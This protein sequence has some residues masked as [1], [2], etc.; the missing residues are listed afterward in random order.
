[1]PNKLPL[2]GGDGPRRRGRAQPPRDAHG[3]H[4]KNLCRAIQDSHVGGKC[5]R[6]PGFHI[7]GGTDA[8]YALSEAHSGWFGVSARAVASPRFRAGRCRRMGITMRPQLRVWSHRAPLLAIAVLV[9]CFA[10]TLS[11]CAH[12]LVDDARAGAMGRLP[13]SPASAQRVVAAP[14]GGAPRGAPPWALHLH[15]RGI[16]PRARWRFP[17]ISHRCPPGIPGFLSAPLPPL[18]GRA[19]QLAQALTWHHS[20]LGTLFWP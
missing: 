9:A 2:R 1:M 10:T 17:R 4:D 13:P 5:T 7:A 8:P 18:P 20:H 11:R 14:R 6:V 3:K 15:T 19:K 12:L 16:L